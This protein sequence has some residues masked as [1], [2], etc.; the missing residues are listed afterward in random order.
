VTVALCLNC[1][2]LKFGALCECFHCGSESTGYD[3]LDVAFTDWLCSEEELEYFGEIVREIGR[4][5]DDY[6]LKSIAFAIYIS[7]HHPD[8]LAIGSINPEVELA[9]RRML[10]FCTF[11]SKKMIQ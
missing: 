5:C 10:S 3:K 6:G 7:D 9:A 11:P 1:G 2:Q 8:N 4:H